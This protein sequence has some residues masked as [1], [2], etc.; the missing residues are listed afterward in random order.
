MNRWRSQLQDVAWI[1]LLGPGPWGRELL[2][3]LG[4]RVYFSSPSPSPSTSSPTI[5]PSRSSLMPGSRQI[6]SLEA[7]PRDPY[8]PLSQS[9]CGKKQKIR[10]S[11]T[12]QMR[13]C[14]PAFPPSPPQR[15]GLTAQRPPPPHSPAFIF[16]GYYEFYLPYLQERRLIPKSTCV[17]FARTSP[18]P[19]TPPTPNTTL[20]SS[21]TPPPTA[22]STP[23][24]S[25]LRPFPT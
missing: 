14:L 25:R 17:F 23:P 20:R 7:D 9:S 11:R 6:P 24:P 4:R 8:H 1:C 12:N 3:V 13:T 22:H 10:I 15:K 18:A 5:R 16:R 2:G 21:P 19:L